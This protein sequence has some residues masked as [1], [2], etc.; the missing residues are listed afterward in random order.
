M[1]LLEGHIVQVV[2]VRGCLLFRAIASGV[3]D[4]HFDAARLVLTD[5]RV[6]L[7]E[8]SLPR[9]EAIAQNHRC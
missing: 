6:S 9:L 2:I 5:P 4:Y 8:F 7:P 1:R 3:I